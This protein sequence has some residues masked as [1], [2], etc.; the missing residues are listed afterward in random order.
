VAKWVSATSLSV[1]CRRWF[2]TRWT[3]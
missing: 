1:L 3:I 2:W